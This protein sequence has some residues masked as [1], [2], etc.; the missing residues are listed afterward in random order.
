VSKR[1]LLVTPLAATAGIFLHELSPELLGSTPPTVH[2]KHLPHGAEHKWSFERDTANDLAWTTTPWKQGGIICARAN[3]EQDLE[4]VRQI[5]VKAQA[6][7]AN[8][9]G[10]QYRRVLVVVELP[11]CD[12]STDG[13][14]TSNRIKPLKKHS[15]SSRRPFRAQKSLKYHLEGYHGQRR[16]TGR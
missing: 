15:R 4:Q 12:K 10:G 7:A 9:S 1:E 16:R 8:T 5:L 14:D 13:S 2:A 11:H 6:T 3:T